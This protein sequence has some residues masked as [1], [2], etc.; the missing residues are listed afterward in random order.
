MFYAGKNIFNTCTSPDL[1]AIV[2]EKWN[3][4]FKPVVDYSKL[5]N[6]CLRKIPQH[7]LD[8]KNRYI[9]GL[10]LL[11]NQLP[12]VK[13]KSRLKVGTNTF[14]NIEGP[15]IKCLLYAKGD[16]LSVH[17][18]RIPLKHG[19]TAPEDISEFGS[20][21]SHV[22]ET[23]IGSIEIRV[24]FR[25]NC[26][27]QIV[28]SNPYAKLP[29]MKHHILNSTDFVIVSLATRAK[30]ESKLY[31][32]GNTKLTHQTNIT[33]LPC[34]EST[35]QLIP[36]CQSSHGNTTNDHLLNYSTT[37]EHAHTKCE[38]SIS[39]STKKYH[40]SFKN[41]ETSHKIPP[42][43]QRLE[44]YNNPFLSQS[45]F[46]LHRD[47]DK[48]LTTFINKV[49]SAML[50]SQQ[51]NPSNSIESSTSD[52]IERSFKLLDSYGSLAASEVFDFSK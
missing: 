10:A 23:P 38:T 36:S 47:D 9:N 2:L 6:E 42:S 18:K 41:R 31:E 27:F 33:K 43:P 25:H 4:I 45:M 3:I 22:F 34:S 35:T 52:I 46:R 51:T 5:K 1:S 50:K 24:R 32:S 21:V 20:Y 30:S 48:D 17:P 8:K 29:L 40:S 7:V 39:K 11:A 49:S 44:T 28:E 14:S 19:I 16:P 37:V 26:N 15:D 13:L 12:A